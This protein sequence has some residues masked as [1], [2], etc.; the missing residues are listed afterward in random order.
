MTVTVPVLPSIEVAIIT[1][2]TTQFG[3]TYRFASTL[4]EGILKM[5]SQGK[6]VSRVKRI[7]GAP[8]TASPF[9]DRPVVD[10]DTFTGVYGTSDLAGRQI[11][12]ALLN[13]RGKQLTIGVVQF[14]RVIVAPRWLPD[15][16]PEL[17]RFGATYQFH[18]HAGGRTM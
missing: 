7:A 2:L 1:E 4:P 10:I 5:S 9:D 15:P 16:N 6:I 3:D 8:Q 11:Q 18:F 13:L 14:T 17:F 12:A